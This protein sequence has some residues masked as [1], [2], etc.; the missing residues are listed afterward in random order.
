MSKTYGGRPGSIDAVAAEILDLLIGPTRRRPCVM[1]RNASHRPTM[2]ANAAC[3]M[4]I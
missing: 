3:D 1:R 2:P 4:N